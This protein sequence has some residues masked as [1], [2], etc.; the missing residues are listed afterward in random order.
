MGERRKKRRK[1]HHSLTQIERY[2]ILQ[3]LHNNTMR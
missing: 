2:V 3:L 1:L